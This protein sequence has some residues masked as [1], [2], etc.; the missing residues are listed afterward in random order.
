MPAQVVNDGGILSHLTCVEYDWFANRLDGG[1]VPMPFGPQDPD[2]DWRTG[3]AEVTD[4]VS[5]YREACATSDQ[6]IVALDLDSIG[7]QADSDCTLRWA[8][9]HLVTETHRH[10]G[11]ADLLRELTDGTHGW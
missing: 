11:H 9:T 5:R 1:T 8:I 6:V 2:G 7:T 3:D 10:A 4:L